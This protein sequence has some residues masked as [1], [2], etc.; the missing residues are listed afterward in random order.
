MKTSIN[1]ILQKYKKG[2][3]GLEE[4]RNQLTVAIA[5]NDFAI[6]TLHKNRS[7]NPENPV[8]TAKAVEIATFVQTLYGAKVG[9]YAATRKLAEYRTKADMIEGTDSLGG[10]LVPDELQAELIALQEGASVVMPYLTKVTMNSDTKK[11]PVLD[12][13]VS[14]AFH[15]E[16]ESIVE[17][18]P[19]FA[20][21]TLTAKRLDGFSDASNELLQDSSIEMLTILLDQFVEQMGQKIDSAV[22]VGTGNPMSGVF[23]ATAGYSAAFDAG[24]TAFSEILVD[25]MIDL[26]H[27]VPSYARRT[28]QIF[29]HGDVLKY[30]QKEK[31]SNGRYRYDP[32]SAGPM[33]VMGRYPIIE[34]HQL[35]SDSDSGAGTACACFGNFKYIVLGNRRKTELLVD[36]Y[37]QAGDYK[38]RIYCVQRLALAYSRTGAFSRLLTAAA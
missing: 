33:Q 36:P 13:S 9:D 11:I 31:D 15:D 5:E 6:D 16:A 2:E 14:V 8:Q 29:M 17:T 25:D 22:F 24:S 35:P 10:Y 21:A 4:F 34:S 27:L 32:Y 20:A 1:D 3:L 30:L 18:E 26:V 23:T 7:Y 28:G 19:T 12:T 38:S 37:T